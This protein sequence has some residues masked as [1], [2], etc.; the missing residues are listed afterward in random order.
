MKNEL[1]CTNRVV[2]YLQLEVMVVSSQE[3][4]RVVNDI[5]NRRRRGGRKAFC[6]LFLNTR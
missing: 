6:P 4:V 2:C 5:Q 1:V 3:R